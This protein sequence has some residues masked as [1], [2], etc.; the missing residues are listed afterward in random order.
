MNSPIADI[1]CTCIVNNNLFR[2]AYFLN[3]ISQLGRM[4]LVVDI[5]TIFS[6]ICYTKGIQ[7]HPLLPCLFS[8][9]RYYQKCFFFRWPF[10]A[11]NVNS[12]MS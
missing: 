7:F 11:E 10:N 9:A 6:S 5:V 12:K 1:Q 2:S 3:S 4:T 8:K